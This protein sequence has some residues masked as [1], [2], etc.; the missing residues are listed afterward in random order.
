MTDE[1]LIEKMEQLE[2]IKPN[3]DWAVLTEQRIL[4]G[5]PEGMASEPAKQP[6][7]WFGFRFIA[8]PAFSLAVSIFAF[9]S[10]TGSASFALAQKSLPGEFLFPLKKVSQNIKM[11]FIPEQEKAVA[12]LELAKARFED[13]SKVTLQEKNQGQKLA[14][15]ISEAQKTLAAA[16]KSL[17]NASAKDKQKIA[18][19]VVGR[20]ESL[21][22]QQEEIEQTIKT[23][24]FND[25]QKSEL[26][27]SAA[28]YYKLYLDNEIAQLEN[29]SLTEAQAVLL[30]EAKDLLADGEV[31]EA[32]NIV[33]NEIPSQNKSATST[34]NVKDQESQTVI[35]DRNN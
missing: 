31:E 7:S 11:A 1:Q 6:L 4:A 3:A 22:N 13:L 17:K 20:L 18:S 35:E 5:L 14:A 19:Q 29:S 8:K 24:I 16:S 12:Q 23:D 27:E 15:S 34:E 9:V 2:C 32:L 10:I 28:V 26:A 21:K 25:V 30:L 33:V